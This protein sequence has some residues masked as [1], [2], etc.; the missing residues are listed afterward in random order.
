MGSVLRVVVIYVFLIVLFRM[1]GKRSMAETTPFD[2]LMLLVL[3]EVTQQAMV[4]EDHSLTNALIMITTF[5]GLDVI[6][7]LLKQ[8]FP[9]L[10]KVL[11]GRPL[12]LVDQGRPLKER[13]EKSRVDEEDILSAARRLHGL[14]RM[15]QVKYA[16]L[17][18]SGDISI[19]P[20]R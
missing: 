12:L 18:T 2:L 20:A 17:E 16:V 10:G 3:S 9:M 8:R 5:V 11:D 15:D 13:M 4:D 19:I 7:S 14:E 6:L 1:A